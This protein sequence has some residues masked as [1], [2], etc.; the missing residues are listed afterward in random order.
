MSL[1]G[2]YILETRGKNIL[3]NDGGFA[4]YSFHE[5]E[6]YI[7]DVYIVPEE[8]N[9]GHLLE[10][11]EEMKV[12]ARAHECKSLITTINCLFKNPTRALRSCLGCGFKI[13]KSL[14]DIIILRM[15]L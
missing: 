10:M 15:E 2:D 5:N 9:N 8:R 11:L 14:N 12:I 3:E 13:D 1:F 7:E 6:C 4:T